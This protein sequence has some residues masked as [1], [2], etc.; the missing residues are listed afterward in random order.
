V[1]ASPAQCNTTQFD[2][3]VSLANT[4]PTHVS[5]NDVLIRTTGA[6]VDALILMVFHGQFNVVD[7]FTI[8]IS[9]N[10]HF[11]S[12]FLDFEKKKKKKKKKKKEKKKKKVQTSR[13]QA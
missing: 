4:L 13:A 10:S 1:L 2:A 6:T 8:L 7:E 12:H 11:F 3:F 9:Q 5:P